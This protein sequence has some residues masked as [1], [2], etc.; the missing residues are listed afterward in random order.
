MA[1]LFAPRRQNPAT[2]FALHA[3]A[4]TV[5]FVAAAHL[6]LK[7]A[8]RQRTLPLSI[9]NKIKSKCVV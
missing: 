1:S 8:F 5:R 6:R 7:R 4:K 2:A 3:R 9:E